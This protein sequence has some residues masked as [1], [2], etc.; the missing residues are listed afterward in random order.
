[1]DVM[2]VR[3]LSGSA[4]PALMVHARSS[5]LGSGDFESHLCKKW[6]KILPDPTGAAPRAR[7]FA[8]N[9][10]SSFAPRDLTEG[11]FR[12]RDLGSRPLARRRTVQ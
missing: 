5:P 9:R 10:G 7:A 12:G 6:F 8:Q 4:V 1:M 3:T 11:H 2:L